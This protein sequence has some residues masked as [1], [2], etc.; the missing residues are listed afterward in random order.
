MRVPGLLA[1]AILLFA[2]EI[3]RVDMTAALVTTLLGLAI[4]LI[5]LNIAF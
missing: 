2:S 3:L 4:S 1:L 5:M